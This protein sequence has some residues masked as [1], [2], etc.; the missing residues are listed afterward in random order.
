MKYFSIHVIRLKYI[1]VVLGFNPGRNETRKQTDESVEK[2]N[3]S[4]RPKDWIFYICGLFWFNVGKGGVLILSLGE[5]MC[6]MYLNNKKY[7]SK[8]FALLNTSL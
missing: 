4:H 3:V 2:Q 6:Q 7:I 8:N 5:M 1:F